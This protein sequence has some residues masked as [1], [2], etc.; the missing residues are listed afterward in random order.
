MSELD[1]DISHYENNDLETFFKL[2]KPYTVENINKREYEIRTLLLSSGHMDKF[3]K[4]DLISFLENG[5]SRLIQ[6]LRP[7]TPP[8]TITTLENKPVPDSYPIPNVPS[9]GREEAIIAPKTTQFMYTQESHHFPGTLNPLERR[10]LQ[11]CLSI[12]TRFRP[13]LSVNSDFTFTLP[14]KITKVLSMNCVSFEMDPCSLYNISASLNNHFFYIS[15]CTVEQE[16][17]QVFVIPD[18]HYDLDLLLDTMNRM[19]AAQSGTPFLFLQ[20]EKDPYGSNKCILLIQ[21][22]NEYYTQRIKHISLDFT[23]DI[24]GNEDKKQDT[25]TKMGYLLGFTQKRYTGQMQYMSNIPVR[26]NSSIPYFYLAVDDFQNR[27][28]SS[29]V[30]SFSQ[31]SISSS[32][33]ARISIKPNGEIQVISNDRKYFGPVDLSRLH[34][35]LLDAH[36]KYLRMDSNYSF[37]LMMHTIYDL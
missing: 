8:T 13:L 17:N 5:K 6:A 35:Q 2:Q 22:D 18:G 27:A 12:D 16:F 30:S 11:K 28:V 10:T 9:I 31:M 24:N 4:R 14:S 34:I 36:G 26:M 7:P 1:L 37:S 20:W 15:I 21:E 29:F 32:I 25:F 23:V 19:F 33:L 3:F